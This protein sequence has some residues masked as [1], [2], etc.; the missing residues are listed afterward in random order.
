METIEYK[1]Q[2]ITRLRI[3]Q[4]ILEALT[5]AIVSKEAFDYSSDHQ[6]VKDA[7]YMISYPTT[8]KALNMISEFKFDINKAFERKF[9]AYELY[10]IF[11]I[12]NM[13]A[14]RL[15]IVSLRCYLNHGH[16]SYFPSCRY[17]DLEVICTRLLIVL[18]QEI[19]NTI[20]F[21]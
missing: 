4:T 20:K 9:V 17:K 18:K 10:E 1:S 5:D 8:N 7:V 12:I 16:D 13:N 3:L 19:R 2:K 15:F 11:H 14:H 21:N 6:I